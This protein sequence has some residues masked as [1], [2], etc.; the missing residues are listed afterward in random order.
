MKKIVSILLL[1]GFI[2]AGIVALIGYKC[3]MTSNVKAEEPKYV[4]IYPGDT[5]ENVLNYLE[6][7]HAIQDM[8]SLKLVA[9]VMGYVEK[10]REGRYEITDGLSNL[11][12]IQKLKNGRQ[13]PVRFTFNNI[14]T[15]DQFAEKV[16]EKLMMSKEEFLKE[17]DSEETLREYQLTKENNIVI[18]IPNT[19]EYYWNIS[20]KEFIT[21]M[22][23]EYDKFW[24]KERIAKLSDCGLSQIEA[25]ILA[26][27]VEEETIK[28]DERPKVAGLY[29]NRLRIGMMLQADPTVKFAIGDFSIK[30][31]T[32]ANLID[33][34]YNTYKNIGLPPGPIRIP[35]AGGIDAVLN[36]AHHNYLFMC[37]KRD[38]SGYHDF[39]ESY[40]EHVNNANKYHKELDKKGIK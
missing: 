11:K 4:E 29:L 16:A 26:S 8:S 22:K 36:Y 12:L 30:R 31:V 28:N 33:S 6:E 25:S 32:G 7:T 34:P 10:I 5:Y 20:P 38:F 39:S 24:T 21:K 17:L 18:F 23:K 1:S 2:I 14:R 13:T 15:K 35:C 37:A 19:Y 40:G 3:F 27:I 9:N